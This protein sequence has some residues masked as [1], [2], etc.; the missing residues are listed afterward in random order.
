MQTQHRP[1]LIFSKVRLAQAIPLLAL[2]ALAAYLCWSLALGPQPLAQMDPE[3]MLSQAL[4]NAQRAG[5]YTVHIAL[6]QSITPQDPFGLRTQEEWSR[7]EIRGDVGGPDKARFSVTPGRTS[8]AQLATAAQELLVR[9]GVTYEWRGE[10]SV[11][12]WS[13]IESAPSLVGVDSDGLSLLSVAHEIYRLEPVSGLPG[14][15]GRVSEYERVGFGLRGPDVLRMMF[16]RQ[17]ALTPRTLDAAQRNEMGLSGSGELWIDSQGLPAHLILDLMWIRQAEIPYRVR[18]HTETDYTSFGKAFAP[19]RFDPSV[20]PGAGEP[21]AELVTLDRLEFA[22]WLPVSVGSLA[23]LWLMWRAHR[24]SRR[25]LRW[26]TILLLVALLMPSFVSVAEAAGW[27]DREGSAAEAK[28][29]VPSPSQMG[30][31]LR[32]MRAVRANLQNEDVNPASFLDEMGDE[33]GDGL[34]NGY[35]IQYGTSPF[36]PDTD[37]DGLSDFDEINGITC[38]AASNQITIKSNPMNPDSNQDGLNDGDEFHQGKCGDSYLLG[39]IWDDDNDND[40]VPDGLDLSPFSWSSQQMLYEGG[41]WPAP[42]YTFETLDQNPDDES[43]NPYPFYVEMQIRPREVNS[44]RWAYK[45]ITWPKDEQAAIQS[46]D[47]VLYQLKKIF[48]GIDSGVSGDV[49]L[50]PFLQATVREKDLPTA[51]SMNAYGVSANQ[52]EDA[53]GNPVYDKGDKLWDMTVPLMTVERGGQIFAFQAK[54]LH[55]RRPGNDSLTRHWRNVRLKWAA[56]ADVLLQDSNGKPVE[57]PNGG[58]GLWVYDEP[59]E[60]TGLQVSR[61]GGASMLVAA[62]LPSNQPYDDGPISLLRGGLEA[63][64]LPG[65]LTLYDVKNRFDTPNSATLEQR[66][67]IPQD[68]QYRVVYDNRHNFKHLDE[69]I[70]TTTMTTT[71]QLLEAEFGNNTPLQPTVLFASEQRTST[72]NLD[73]TPPKDYLDITLNT[74]LK[75]LVTSRSLKLQTYQNVLEGDD[76]IGHWEPMSLDEVLAKIEGEYV[77]ST[78]ADDPFYDEH[79]IILKMAMTTWQLGVTSIYK[80]GQLTLFELKSILTDPQVGLAFLEQ[81]GLIPKGTKAVVDKLLDI[82]AKGGP[83][84]FLQNLWTTVVDTWNKIDHFF[85]GSYLDLANKTPDSYIKVI[86]MGEGGGGSAPP[87][88]PGPPIDLQIASYTQTAL[89]VLGML[90]TLIGNETFSTVVT[91]L[92]KIVQI[93]QQFRALVDTIKTIINIAEKAKNL[94]Q[95]AAGFAK[96]LAAMVK[97]MQVVGLIF[98]VAIIWLGVLLQIGDLGPNVAL[99]VVLRAIVETVLAVVLF[100]VALI[101]PYGTI[102]AIAIGLIKMIESLIGFQFDPI[103]LLLD[104]LFGVEAVLRTDLKGDPQFG[105]LK[106]EA[107]EPGAGVVAN[108][109]FRLSLPASAT[110]HTVNDGSKSALNQSYARLHVGRFADWPDN[111]PSISLPTQEVFNT[112]KAEAGSYYK[113][114]FHA[115]E[116]H[117][118][119]Y[120]IPTAGWGFTAGHSESK[121]AVKSVGGGYQRTDSLLGWVDVSPSAGIN[122][123]LVLDI[124]MDVRIRYDQ[125]S[126][127]GGCDAYTND[128]TSPPAFQE[129]Y[130]DILPGSLKSLWHWD[131]LANYDYDGDGLSGYQDPIS[132]QV[133]GTEANLCPNLIGVKTWQE[134][135]SDGD[136]L[137]DY[138]EKTTP[139]FN[140]CKADTDGDGIPDGRELLIGTYADDKDTDNDGLTDQEED[141]FDNGFHIQWPWLVSLASQYPGLPNPPAFPNPRQ[142]NFDADYRNDK[143]EKEKASS[144]T[145]Y[146]AVPVGDPLAFGIG[147]S[148]GPGG[149]QSF[150]LQSAPWANSEAIALNPSLTLTMPVG[151]AGPTNS[152]KLNPPIFVPQLNFGYLDPDVAGPTVYRWLLPPLSLNRYLQVTLTGVPGAAPDPAVIHATL[153]YDEGGVHQSFTTQANLLVNSGGP[154]VNFTNV[155]GAAVISG[156]DGGLNSASLYGPGLAYSVASDGIV[157]LSGVAE[158]PDRVGQVFVCIT[159]GGACPNNGWNSALPVGGNLSVWSFNYDPPADGQYSVW[160]Y[161][162]DAHG[163]A[164][165]AAGPVVIGVDQA[166]PA[167]FKL[168]QPDFLFTQTAFLPDRTP[169]VLF[170]GEVEDAAGPHMAGAGSVALLYG[171]SS[172]SA[173]VDQIGQQKSAFSL[174]WTPPAWG[175]GS[176]VRTPAGYYELYIGGA[177]QAGNVHTTAKT[178]RVVVDDTPPTVYGQPPQTQAGLNFTLTGL[179]DDTA[180]VRKRTA[181]PPFVGKSSANAA[182]RFDTASALGRAVVLGDLNGDAIDDAVLLLPALKERADTPTKALLFFGKP[183]GLPAQL[184]SSNAD[185]TLTGE[186]PIGAANFSPSAARVGDVNGDGVDDLFVGD[187]FADSGKGRAYLVLG[188]RSAWAKSGKLAD[189]AWKLS[190][191]GT[192]GYGAAVAGA[193]DVNGDGLP[194]LLVGAITSN[195]GRQNGGG[196]LYLGREQGIP[197]AKAAFTPP[198]GATAAPPSLAGVGDANGDGLS[199]MLLA[200]PGAPVALVNGRTSDG[201]PAGAIPLGSQANALFAARGSA[202]TVAAAGDVNG[203]GLPDLLV[204][205]PAATTPTLFLLYGRR[206]EKPWPALPATLALATQADASWTGAANSRLGAGLASL[207]D[208]DDDGLADLLA[209]QPGTGAGPNRVGILLSS[210][211]LRALN[212]SFDAA[213]QLIPGTANSQKL[214]ETLSAGDLT[215]DHIPDLLLGAPGEKAAYLL[216]GD[217]DPGAVAGVTQVEVGFF[218]PLAN[219]SQPLSATLPSAWTNATLS[220]VNGAIT[221]WSAGLLLPAVGDYRLYARATDRAGNRTPDAAGYLGTVWVTNPAQPFSGTLALDPAG[222]SQQTQ[223]AL[224][225]SLNTDRA[226][227]HLRLY[228]GYAWHRLPPITGSYAQTTTIPHTDLR[229]LSLRAVARDAFGNTAQAQR[230]L[231]VDSLA[232]GPRLSDNLPT[233]LWQTDAS[234]V[235]SVTWPAPQ[236]ASGIAALRGAIDTAPDSP[237]TASLAQNQLLKTLDGPGIFYAHALVEDGAGNRGVSRSGPYLVNRSTTP[238]VIL[239]DGYL[240]S[241]GGEYPN[242]ALLGYDPFALWKPT[243]LWGTWDAQKLYLAFPGNRW[244]SKSWLTFYLDTQPGGLQSGLP[245]G[246]EHKLPFGADFALRVGGESS[247]GFDLYQANGSWQVVGDPKSFVARDP[248]TEVVID[249]TEV[250][251]TGGLKLLALAEDGDGAWALLPASARPGTDA[252]LTGPLEVGDGMQ[253]GGLENGVRPNAGLKQIVAPQVEVLTDW[254]NSLVAGGAAAFRVIIRNPDIGPYSGAALEVQADEKLALNRVEGARCTNCPANGNRWSLAVDVAAGGVQTVTLYATALGQE[255]NGVAALPLEVWLGDSALPGA[256]QAKFRGQYWLDHATTRMKQ[257]GGLSEVYVQ[258]GEFVV[259]VF[260]DID[261]T[262]LGRCYSQ[263]EVNPGVSGWTR[264]CWLGDCTVV[265]GTIAANANQQL[266]V[267]TTNNRNG[268]SSQPLV[269]N[270]IADATAPS[271]TLSPTLVLS[272]SLAFV[273]G[274]AWDGFPT[275]RAPARVEVQIDDG[276]FFPALLAPG[277]SQ[278]MQAAD[279]SAV[280]A[281]AAHWRLP[282]HLTWED[283]KPVQVTARSIDEAGNVGALLKPL[284]ILLDNLGPQLTFEQKQ[285]LLQGT[286]TDGSGVASVE[287]SLDGG[288]NF[289][290]V[291][292]DGDA[293]SFGLDG[294]PY[295]FAS[296][297]ILRAAD[298]YGNSNRLLSPYVLVLSPTRKL[299]LPL[300]LQGQAAEVSSA[301]TT[302]PAHRLYLPLTVASE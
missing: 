101:F 247:R 26:L 105:Q 74:C 33:D 62:A 109:D 121:G 85:R 142:A 135:D 149:K 8:F 196:W 189:A 68:Q 291:K 198:A 19:S 73:E 289:V 23:L 117:I 208:V 173:P 132:K 143:K 35:E 51:A 99:S 216:H 209:G 254:D 269:L 278:Q 241:R 168:D 174:P 158:D 1:H 275:S 253:W 95:A 150:V 263:V 273:E 134:W 233:G 5:S 102:V 56:V 97:P 271:A 235:L 92:T 136:G 279:G 63:Q 11:D 185:V 268:R 139:R 119:Y 14:P 104:W 4:E 222:L 179:A 227:Q 69:A 188:K 86:P 183:G 274:L 265:R 272:G 93:Y 281:M 123:R 21:V 246:P 257:A 295:G 286:V 182:S 103:S 128:S 38:Q 240:D 66:W 239:P 30:Q 210:Q 156:L 280:D 197:G 191:A 16:G 242:G 157:T 7:F 154:V 47:P 231:N 159:G 130:M 244:N 215:G 276:P 160:A 40:K 137:S 78:P 106:M 184:N 167:N 203:D 140:P 48:Q 43:T 131:A 9:D 224:L 148:F 232:L 91:I 175:E 108:A 153:E 10:S 52:Q 58:W 214:G 115:A 260:A 2:L 114:E 116:A 6:S 122:K 221:P 236:D 27:R 161:A 138:F 298:I 237:P 49:Q 67:N 190:V 206:P 18:A 42:N 201:W 194:D 299:Y 199:D 270:V 294:W 192:T 29:S 118:I 170:T 20:A 169:V 243:A 126:T 110:L 82:W 261:F 129:F 162:I 152:A 300:T 46:G 41:N 296:V 255:V 113:D 141:P 77:A 218:G 89:M 163:K 267:R 252:Q 71:K 251:L 81:D 112:Y 80:I 79:L 285:S 249:R 284:E 61:Q 60:L 225:G 178:V 32:D 262:T 193:G 88:P 84:V 195:S 31:L 44:L 83:V 297:A 164:G 64:F 211:T 24:G 120:N 245:G 200:F 59:Y 248:D 165:A 282:L 55:D 124:A 65:G 90:A 277:V 220:T 94:V 145:S 57:S 301:D 151:L 96:E 219:S 75:P 72:V 266:Q 287:I 213:A 15:D 238:S 25:A 172:A 223:L 147:Q 202:P 234:P 176:S 293:W 181:T 34:P 187:P 229:T 259:D 146:N 217:F 177:D 127:V 302:A 258:P 228:D 70:A 207:G 111:Y 76:F 256:P 180:L 53:A 36:A 3:K 133:Y 37:Y 12:R 250:M 155:Q 13:R 98:A 22:L 28:Q 283:G 107:L 226:G 288:V 171:D 290:G 144:P 186:L 54:M 264:A 166:A 292:F 17:G 205:D 230:T 45:H 204:G 39:W 87:A 125:C 100:V 212:Q 50:V